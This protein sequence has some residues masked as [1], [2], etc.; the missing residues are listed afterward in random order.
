MSGRYVGPDLPLS[1]VAD[2]SDG[3][4]LLDSAGAVLGSA[5][6]EQGASEV[7]ATVTRKGVM[8]GLGHA[9]GSPLIDYSTP[10]L[11]EPGL[12]VKVPL[13][14]HLSTHS[15]RRKRPPPSQEDGGRW[16][17]LG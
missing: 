9:D 1:E 13:L 16:A 4:T 8:V 6:P 2:I 3:I 14:V 17:L 12:E 11:I 7:V 15:Q 10:V 5:H